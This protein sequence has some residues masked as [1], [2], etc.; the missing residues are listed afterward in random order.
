MESKWAVSVIADAG[1]DNLPDA[2]A[3]EEYRCYYWGGK[4]KRHIAS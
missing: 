2:D 4:T 3:N 1:A